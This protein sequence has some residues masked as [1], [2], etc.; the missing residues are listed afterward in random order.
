MVNLRRPSLAASVAYPVILVNHR[1][2]RCCGFPLSDSVLLSKD[3]FNLVSTSSIISDV[4]FLLLLLFVYRLFCARVP[5]RVVV[6]LVIKSLFSPDHCYYT[7]IRC[8]KA[9]LSLAPLLPVVKL[10]FKLRR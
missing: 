4:V 5:A 1:S 9:K 7:D 3:G 8:W 10:S 2:V 6:V